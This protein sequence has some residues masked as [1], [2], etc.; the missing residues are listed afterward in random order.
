M[1]ARGKRNPFR[2]VASPN[3]TTSLFPFHI[4]VL[5]LVIW[6]ARRGTDVQTD[7]GCLAIINNVTRRLKAAISPPVGGASRGSFLGNG[8]RTSSV[9][10]VTN[11]LATITSETQKRTVRGG[12]FYSVRQEPLSGRLHQI[13]L[14][15]RKPAEL[16]AE[17]QKTDYTRR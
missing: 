15:E 5:R 14:G 4:L 12:V 1:H 7:D 11:T 8:Y 16:G 2:V 17:T 13:T 10:A 3:G 6:K 9:P